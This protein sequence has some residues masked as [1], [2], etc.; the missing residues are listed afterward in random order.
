VDLSPG[1]HPQNLPS[2]AT[3]K[4]IL[5][6]RPRILTPSLSL[7]RPGCWVDI[8]PSTLYKEPRNAVGH[9]KPVYSISSHSRSIMSA[10]A[11]DQKSQINQ[12]SQVKHHESDP[13]FLQ[14]PAPKAATGM[15]ELFSN[16][17][18]L[19]WCAFH[20]V[21]L[22]ISPAKLTLCSRPPH[23]HPAHQLWLRN[24]PRRQHPVYP[25]L[26]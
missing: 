26:P 20:L 13:E 23:L 2:F 9:Q 22:S 18:I 10:P 7:S 12:E 8:I 24:R 14:T 19:G 3:S 15:K 1:L 16:K 17:R 4:W 5:S 21:Y 11:V 25:L 6:P